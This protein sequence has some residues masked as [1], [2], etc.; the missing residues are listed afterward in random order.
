[1]HRQ[2]EDALAHACP[3]SR[4]PAAAESPGGQHH[5]AGRHALAARNA[6]QVKRGRAGV[7]GQRAHA[8][9]VT[10]TH[11]AGRDDGFQRARRGDVHGGGLDSRAL[12]VQREVGHVAFVVP[13]HGD[14]IATG[15]LDRLRR[16]ALENT[17]LRLTLHRRL[18]VAGD[19][20]RA[21]V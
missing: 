1:M 18:A 2:S 3:V 6:V 5:R 21:A 10:S 9:L 15:V 14:E 20:A 13:L 8:G 19:V 12:A 17:A 4:E 11:A 16:D 7:E